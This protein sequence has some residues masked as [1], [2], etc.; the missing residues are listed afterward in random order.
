MS[1]FEFIIAVPTSGKT[2]YA[3]S[4]NAQRPGSVLDMD[5]LIANARDV[6]EHPLKQPIDGW[7]VVDFLATHDGVLGQR[8]ATDK[9]RI[10]ELVV[11]EAA[12]QAATELLYGHAT[13]LCAWTPIFVDY[14]MDYIDKYSNG[15]SHTYNTHFFNRSPKDVAVLWQRRQLTNFVKN[16]KL[17]VDDIVTSTSNLI[18]RYEEAIIHYVRSE[19][20]RMYVWYHTL[21]RHEFI[22]TFSAERPDALLNTI[23]RGGKYG[24]AE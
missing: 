2:H 4:I 12:S 15:E 24:E 23:I 9:E 20:S 14:V 21:K 3:K 1:T 22:A 8:L 17:T 18:K 5:V 7:G 16:R 13:T 6:W 10:Y 19:S 11:V